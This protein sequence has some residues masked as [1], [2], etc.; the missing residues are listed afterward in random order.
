MEK[1]PRVSVLMPIYNGERYLADAIKSVLAQ[2]C[3]HWELILMNDGSTD[4]SARIAQSYLARDARIRYYE[5]SNRG[6]PAALNAALRHATGVYVAALAQDDQWLPDCLQTLVNVLEKNPKAAATYGLAQM[7]DANGN[8]LPQTFGQV[9]P[10]SQLYDHLI[11][12]NFIPACAVMIRRAA[13]D[14]VG[15]YD[16]TLYF[17]DWDL[18][19]RLAAVYPVLSVPA[20][21]FRYRIHENNMTKQLAKME[22]GKFAVVRKHFGEENDNIAE[23]SV[24]KRRAYAGVYYRSAID[25]LSV[26][27]GVKGISYLR[28]SFTLWP[29]L[30]KRRDPYYEIA[31]AYQPL[32]ERG[33]LNALDLAQAT[34]AVETVLAS[35]LADLPTTHPLARERKTIYGLAYQVL[36]ELALGCGVPGTANQF[37]LRAVQQDL[38]RLTDIKYLKTFVR[39]FALPQ[40][41]TYHA[42]PVS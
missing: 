13:L 36:G 17:E 20:I 23:W 22:Q 32:G 39:A 40:F 12:G 35:L 25:Y 30:Y 42:N 34:N 3:P 8:D 41:K 14:S 4:G 7:M 5:Q 33:N 2:T 27:D 1:S 6:L 21:V 9:L 19:L 26:G 37:L 16:E 15:W 38:L 10:P 28:K 11:E 31:C 24:N 18:W 29:P